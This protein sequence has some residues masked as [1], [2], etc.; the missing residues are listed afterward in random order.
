MLSFLCKL[1]KPLKII[2]LSLIFDFGKYVM[3]GYLLISLNFAYNIEIFKNLIQYI[4]L[5]K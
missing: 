1:I 4:Y 3:G 2:Y 5:K